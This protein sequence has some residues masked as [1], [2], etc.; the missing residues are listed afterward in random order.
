MASGDFLAR[1]KLA[2]EGKAAVVAG[3]KETQA[4]AQKLSSTKVTTTYDKSGVATGKQIQE[5][6]KGIGTEAKKSS[7]DMGDFSRAISRAAIVAPVWMALRSAMM[8]VIQTVQSQIKFLL[9]LEDA[10]ARI[11]IVGKGNAEQYKNLAY[12]LTGLAIAYGISAT[13][14]L[15]AA[16]IFAQQGKTVSETFVLTRAAMIGAQ[17]LGT[18]VTDATESMTAAMNS[19]GIPAQNAISIIDK[20]IAVEKEFAVT[21]QDLAS[22]V[23]VVGAS[24]NQVGVSLAALTG[25]ITAVVEVTRK[26]GSEAA[27]G[28]QF[29]YA[30]LL[31][32][33]RPVIEQLTGI[34]YY[35]D[36]NGKATSALTGTLRNATDILDE[37][38]GKW[39]ELTNQER[40]SVA[41]SLGSKRQLVV[42][43]ALMQNYSH[44]LD[45][46]VVALTSAG[47]AEK[48]LNILMETTRYKHQQLISSANALTLAIGGS[49]AW[50]GLIDNISLALLYY[51]KLIDFE[52]GYRI[53]LAKESTAQLANIETRQSQ[54][55]SIE[56]LISLRDK[57]M[58]GPQSD[59]NTER[60]AQI[61]E[62]IKATMES[63]PALKL[64]VESGDSKEIQRVRKD[65]EDKLL[66]EKITVQVGVDFIPQLAVL[67]K[68]KAEIQASLDSMAPFAEGVLG[69]GKKEKSEIAAIDEKR[70]KLVK[71]QTKEAEKQLNLAKANKIEKDISDDEEELILRGELTAKEK[72]SLEIERELN[73]FKILSNSTTEQQIIKEM[74]L[75]KASDAVYSAHER[76]LKL[77]KLENDL[78]DAKLKKRDDEINK[79]GS[80]GMQYEKAAGFEKSRI[81]R[82]AELSLMPAEQVASI[83]QG[84]QGMIGDK[85]IIE[86]FWSSFTGEAQKSIQESTTLFKDLNY[87]IPSVESLTK[88]PATPGGLVKPGQQLISIS[89]TAN[90][91]VNI[92]LAMEAGVAYEKLVSVATQQFYEQLLKNK[93]KITELAKK[94]S[95][96]I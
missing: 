57:L 59:K 49:S 95:P 73:N 2:L 90:T 46:R 47:Q 81:R 26:S 21:S 25:D 68:K 12:S 51:T 65:I 60:I 5:T 29:I 3:L 77:S 50:K 19:F 76:T 62:A 66:A 39:G 7:S 56:E 9:D 28:L 24:A 89:P 86:D 48:A 67:D 35:M 93:D 84:Q 20:F 34:K 69:W 44:S 14:A 42:L 74:E 40:L 37:V 55:T 45:A 6:F 52:K 36:A 1:I 92:A 78:I 53:E 27:R 72:E 70:N 10:M 80:L 85:K 94:I 82:A 30:R 31:T 4:A 15:N 91:T 88:A 16:K 58:S 38:A 13:E 87:K 41:E 18:T 17:V 63:Q 32:S 22:G 54:I 71:E 33:G 8:G 43:N 61:N 79:L 83:Y 75:V 23:K 96:Q 11:Q 64:A